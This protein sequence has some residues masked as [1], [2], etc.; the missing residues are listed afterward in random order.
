MLLWLHLRLLVRPVQVLVV[1]KCRAHFKVR[2]HFLFFFNISSYLVMVY[3]ACVNK[4]FVE[5]V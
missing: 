1:K 5:Y 3:F 2:H 4:Y